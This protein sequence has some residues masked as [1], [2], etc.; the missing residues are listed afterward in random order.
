MLARN[1]IKPYWT[2][3]VSCSTLASAQNYGLSTVFI[4]SSTRD[5]KYYADKVMTII[6]HHH[7]I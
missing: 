5:I 4:L 6:E 7:G 1:T 2:S 3:Q